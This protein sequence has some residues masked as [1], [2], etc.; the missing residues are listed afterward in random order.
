MCALLYGAFVYYLINEK[1]EKMY[2]M[3]A[4]GGDG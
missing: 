2:E 1:Q 4:N 3:W